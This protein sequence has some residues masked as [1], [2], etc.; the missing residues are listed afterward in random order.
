[1]YQLVFLLSGLA[2]FLFG[3]QLL[4]KLL[5]S[6][7]GGDLD[8]KLAKYTKN[9]LVKLV[10]GF[11]VT[12]LFQSSS[13]TTV[14]M[15][16]M[17]SVGLI[18]VAESL[19]FIL[20]ANIGS[21]TTAWIVAVKITK[22]GIFLFTIG[23]IGRFITSSKKLGNIFD[24]LAGLGLIFFGLEMMS[25]SLEFVKR[26]PEVVEFISRFSAETSIG[27]MLILVLFGIL[28]TAV[29]QSSGA[30][31]AMVITIASQGILDLHSACAV[32]L[33]STLGT[34]ITAFLASLNAGALG[35]RTAFINVI[36]MLFGMA[37]FYPSIDLMSGLMAA[38]GIHVSL[39]IATY[40]TFIKI[41]LV[42]I[43][44]PI[45]KYVAKFSEML[46]REKFQTIN[47][48]PV[49]PDLP[50]NAD[51]FVIASNL[52][53]NVDTFMKYLTDMLAFSYII[54]RKPKESSLFDKVVKYEKTLDLGHRK[55]VQS[56]SATGNDRNALLW[57]YLKMSD[58]AESMGDHARSIAKY[59]IKLGELHFQFSDDQKK[60]MLEAHTKIFVQF[61]KVC[62]KK[63]YNTE[64]LEESHHIE[65]FLRTKKRELYTTLCMETGHN[66]E[67]RLVL[68]DILSE[69]SKINHS[70]KRILQVNL[71][72]IEGRGIY[73]WEK[74]HVQGKNIADP[75]Q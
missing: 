5:S 66:P 53:K 30:T 10:V 62:V 68:T 55:M 38:K 63:D 52:S 58:E 37:F 9:D 22:A 1:M 47:I 7:T 70:I 31:A 23:I 4:G 28:F 74:K 51:S 59:G 46:I 24:F 64:L 42:I 41:A 8:E 25:D 61:H 67:K 3:M 73:L 49:T 57:L 14:I 27:S 40:M 11:V 20:G 72:I 48:K 32:V 65:R 60:L 39:I 2:F 13:A 26:S 12:T 18:S 33:G 50:Y 71:D 44:F 16:S 43:V 34:T 6:F 35:K 15:V 36:G 29:I 56:I 17:T 75:G 54:M 21:I 69:Y 45:R 19:S